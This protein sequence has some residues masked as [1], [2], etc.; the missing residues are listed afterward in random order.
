MGLWSSSLMSVTTFKGDPH[1]TL[2]PDIDRDSTV[3]I[4]ASEYNNNYARFVGDASITGSPGASDFSA[5]KWR[6]LSLDPSRTAST[7]QTARSTTS[8]R[9]TRGF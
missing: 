2:M 5:Q 7:P 1:S 3:L 4:T 8:S 6:N 9:R